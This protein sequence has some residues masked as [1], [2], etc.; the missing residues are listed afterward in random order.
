MSF[1]ISPFIPL[2]TSFHFGNPKFVSYIC[3]SISIL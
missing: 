2:P 1:P 3:D